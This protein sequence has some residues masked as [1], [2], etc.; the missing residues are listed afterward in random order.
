MDAV[1]GQMALFSR[2]FIRRR[3]ISAGTT[4]ALSGVSLALGQRAPLHRLQPARPHAAVIAQ[5]VVGPRLT[6]AMPVLHAS[7][8]G[9]TTDMMNWEWQ[10]T[11]TC[12][13]RV[14]PF[15]ATE[16]SPPLPPSG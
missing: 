7:S 8:V 16:P 10:P 12:E 6:P 1:R 15:E 5:P 4:L 9:N 3:I 13:W 11:H 2:S 14:H